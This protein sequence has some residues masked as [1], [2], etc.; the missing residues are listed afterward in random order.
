MNNVVIVSGG[1]QRDSVIYIHASI[2]PQTSL[3]SRLPHNIEQS[4]LL[5]AAGPWLTPSFKPLM[6]RAVCYT[7]VGDHKISPQELHN[8]KRNAQFLPFD[9]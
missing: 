2:L 5:C 1:E 8:P 4:S 7:A 9:R 3:A 6:F